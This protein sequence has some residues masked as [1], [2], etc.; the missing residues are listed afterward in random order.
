QRS[1]Q[2]TGCLHT[3]LGAMPTVCMQP[4]GA[5][6]AVG[7]YPWGPRELDSGVIK[8][9]LSAY[10]PRGNANCLHA[11]L[12]GN[13]SCWHISV[14]KQRQLDSG[15]SR[16]HVVCIQPSGQC[17]LFA[18]SPWGQRQ[19]LAYIRGEATAARQRTEQAT[20]CLHTALGAMPTVCMQ[21]LGATAAVGIYP[22]GSNGS[23]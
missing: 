2:A 7:I 16:L 17:Q 18:C 10:S 22:W 12:G 20:R 21:P 4:L 5:T 23:A 14:G 11:A 19:L 9:R 3:A 8:L 15:L 6:A 13:G 1:D